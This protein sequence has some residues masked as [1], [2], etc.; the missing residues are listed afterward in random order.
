M[1]SFQR[2]RAAQAQN[3]ARRG[4]SSV[5]FALILPVFMTFLVGVTE[6]SLMLLTQH[7]LENATY[8]ASR[9]GKTG[10][11]DANKTQMDAVM[12]ALI[13]RLQSLS[14]LIDVGRVRLTSTAYGDLSAIGQPDQGSEGLGAPQ[15]IVVYTVSYPWTFFTPMIGQLMGDENNQRI[16]SSRIVVRNEPYD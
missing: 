10:H 7:L 13:E 1:F 8:N 11:V 12:G 9:M 2:K 16:L 5:E 15:Q 3:K 6:M 14:P 4:I